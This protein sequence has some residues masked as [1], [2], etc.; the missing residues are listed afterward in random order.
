[1]RIFNVPM[2]VILG[3]PVPTPLGKR[4]MLAYIVGRKSGKTYRQPVSYVKDGDT[5]L[6][7]GGG[8]WTRNLV[9]NP[10]VRLRVRRR[11]VFA[12]A[13][14]VGDVENVSRLLSLIFLSNLSAAAFVGIKMD[15]DGTLDLEDLRTVIDYG[16]R[17]VRWHLD[18]S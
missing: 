1:M 17:V 5:L 16:F 12:H 10:R 7:P 6:T 4:L 9:E 15:S 8:R 13:E 11:D 2:R 14:L 18:G 3:L